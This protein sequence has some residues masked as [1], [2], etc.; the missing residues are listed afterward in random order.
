ML[1]CHHSDWI[2]RDRGKFDEQRQPM[3]HR[4][5]GFPPSRSAAAEEDEVS[6]LAVHF[7]MFPIFFCSI[8]SFYTFSFLHFFL[9]FTFFFS[10]FSFHFSFLF[11]K[12]FKFSNFSFFD[13]HF[14][15]CCF[16]RFF[17]KKTMFFFFDIFLKKTFLFCWFFVVFRLL[18]F[19]TCFSLFI[20]FSCLCFARVSFHFFAFGWFFAFGQVKSNARDGRSRHRP[21]KLRIPRCRVHVWPHSA[22]ILS[23]HYPAGNSNAH[24]Y[25]VKKRKAFLQP[26]WHAHTSPM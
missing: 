20:F 18:F 14:V 19:L 25:T 6:S 5:E 9:F 12:L 3:A 23:M 8:F 7:F 26:R 22:P 21:T 16:F 10:F 2:R 11:L 24:M 1:S 17:H 13:S 15:F 4:G